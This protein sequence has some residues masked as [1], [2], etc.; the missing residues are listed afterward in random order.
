MHPQNLIILLQLAPG[1]APLAPVLARMLLK[2]YAYAMIPVSLWVTGWASWLG[3][4]VVC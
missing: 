3:V 4:Q 1:T 2:L